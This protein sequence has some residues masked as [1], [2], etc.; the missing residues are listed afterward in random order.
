MTTQRRDIII[1]RGDP[2]AHSIIGETVDGV[3]KDLTGTW[4]AQIR[5]YADS[6][7]ITATFNVDVTDAAA[8]TVVLSL[9]DTVTA[10]FVPGLY[11]WDVDWEDHGTPIG[12]AVTV[13]PDVTR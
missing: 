7:D 2:Y 13:T 9:T 10:A 8:G 3:S 11:V 1:R 12:G 6:T 4:A 5:P